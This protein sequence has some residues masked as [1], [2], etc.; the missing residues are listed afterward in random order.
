MVEN[1][2]EESWIDNHEM[3]GGKLKRIVILIYRGGI[4]YE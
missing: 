3:H 1:V 4:N 2:N